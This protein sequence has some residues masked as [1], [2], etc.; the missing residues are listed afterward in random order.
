MADEEIQKFYKSVNEEEAAA[1]PEAAA[2]T[3]DENIKGASIKNVSDAFNKN[4]GKA[5]EAR[6]ATR[7]ADLF[8]INPLSKDKV[9]NKNRGNKILTRKKNNKPNNNKNKR[10]ALLSQY[11]APRLSRNARSIV[12]RTKTR[13]NSIRKA[14]DNQLRI[15]A[16][17]KILTKTLKK[18][19]NNLK[20]KKTQDE[21]KKAEKNIK[22]TEDQFI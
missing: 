21:I 19:R 12:S 8:G 14:R 7:V 9:K 18:E 4:I 10:V 11:K 1:K 6:E 20:T 15:N 17:I 2:N 5:A 22:M 13:N 3:N 16:N